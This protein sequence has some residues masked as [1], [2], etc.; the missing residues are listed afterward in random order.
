MKHNRECLCGRCKKLAERILKT[1]L[2][3]SVLTGVQL[4][5]VAGLKLTYLKFHGTVRA[6]KKE[7]RLLRPSPIRLCEL[8][9]SRGIK[10]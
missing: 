7:G 5:G 1:A 9:I 2:V 3:N 6:E 10:I 8:L 4:R